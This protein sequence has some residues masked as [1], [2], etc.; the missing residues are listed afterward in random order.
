M[1]KII[2]NL[3]IT[4]L[5]ISATIFSSCKKDAHKPPVVEFKTGSGLHTV[6]GNNLDTIA[7]NT[8][9]TIGLKVTKVEDE[10]KSINV[11]VAYDGSTNTTSIY[12]ANTSHSQYDGFED[13]RPITTRN[14]AGI[15]KFTFAVVDFDGNIGTAVFTAVVK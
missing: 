14:Q 3:T 7:R 5:I 8:T 9:I 11:S 1:N 13:S 6:L 12:N 4:T 2:F 10:L 15:E